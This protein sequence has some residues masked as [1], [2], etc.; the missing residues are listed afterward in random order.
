D[1]LAWH[2]E[3]DSHRRTGGGGESK[4]L[5]AVRRDGGHVEILVP[6]EPSARCEPLGCRAQALREDACVV[7][8]HADR[9]LAAAQ[10]DRRRPAP[11]A[12]STG[13]VS[14]DMD[15]AGVRDADRVTLF[16]SAQRNPEAR[17]T[18]LY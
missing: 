10:A 18:Q 7:A 1:L 16:H 4:R 8:G 5:D 2:L 13:V 11:V 15:R 6:R 12:G 14:D 17:M 3:R 9:G